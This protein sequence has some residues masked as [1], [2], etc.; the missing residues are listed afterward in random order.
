M[1]KD[2]GKE[3]PRMEEEI[4]T[5]AGAVWQALQDKEGVTLPALRKEVGCEAPVLDWAIGWLAREDKILI[6]RVKRSYQ[7]RLRG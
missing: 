2:N 5:I 1:A 4:G 3:S 7:V 6:T